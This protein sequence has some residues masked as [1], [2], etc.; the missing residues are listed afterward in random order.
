RV[1][2]AAEV[3]LDRGEDGQDALLRGTVEVAPD[4][5][6]TRDPEEVAMSAHLGVELLQAL[7]QD[8]ALVHP[9]LERGARAEVRD[10]ADVVVQAL[11]LEEDAAD[12]QR[13]PAR[14]NVGERPYRLRVRDGVRER[15]HAAQTL[16]EMQDT[17]DA[18]PFGGLLDAA[19]RVE[20][21]RLELQDDLPDA[22][23]AEVAGLDDP[24][25]DRT[26]GHLHHALAPDAG[27]RLVRVR[28][29]G[30]RARRVEVLPQRVEATRPIVVQHEAPGIGMALGLDAE[31]VLGL[32][33]VPVRGGHGARHRRIDR[34][35]R[36]D[37]RFHRAQLPI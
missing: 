31:E 28:H 5:A 29:A 12:Q 10:V 16:R 27:H 14:R 26:D 34:A 22:A 36:I 21:A 1:D 13:P 2:V 4:A 25:M 24:G 11:E 18:L 15:A 20:E 17:I 32:P 23:E 7:L 37:L 30:H 19:M 6:G 8:A 9:E 35:R 33:L 3:R